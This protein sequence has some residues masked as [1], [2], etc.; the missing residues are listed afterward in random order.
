MNEANYDESPLTAKGISAE[1]VEALIA[2]DAD[3]DGAEARLGRFANEFRTTDDKPDMR[4]RKLVERAGF[5]LYKGE[6]LTK[7]HLD[8]DPP[9]TLGPRSRFDYR[10]RR[11]GFATSVIVQKRR[12]KLRRLAASEARSAAVRAAACDVMDAM[13]VLSRELGLPVV[14]MLSAR[15]FVR[16]TR[17][18]RLLG[19]VE[20]LTGRLGRELDARRA[21]LQGLSALLGEDFSKSRLSSSL[22][23]ARAARKRG[24]DRRPE[25]RFE[26]E[27][28]RMGPGALSGARPGHHIQ[29][30]QTNPDRGT[31]SC[32]TNCR[33]ASRR[34][35]TEFS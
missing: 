20:S 29:T 14:Q 26:A 28:L 24:R 6:P 2:E 27:R 16:E 5:D 10:A 30:V 15:E 31:N 34:C 22:L 33:R 13:E 11:P 9:A 32:Q 25:R 23:R 7:D 18:E 8:R 17:D 1:V 4:Y 21:V 19:L 12:Q 3:H 35:P